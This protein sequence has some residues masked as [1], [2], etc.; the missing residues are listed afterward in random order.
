MS[1][2]K[3]FTEKIRCRVIPTT[4]DRRVWLDEKIVDDDLYCVFINGRSYEL[5]EEYDDF[6]YVNAD[7]FAELADAILREL[8]ARGFSSSGY[9]LVNENHVYLDYSFLSDNI[10]WIAWHNV[11]AIVKGDITD[12]KDYRRDKAK[13]GRWMSYAE[14]VQAIGK[15]QAHKI[16]EQL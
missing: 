13:H 9:K 6:L 1:N 7:N 15:N 3:N 5:G 4:H 14:L 16:F 11:D 8:Y 2:F 12:E 10:P